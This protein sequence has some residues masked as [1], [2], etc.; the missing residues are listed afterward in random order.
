MSQD[1]AWSAAAF[2]GASKHRQA[3]L[4]ALASS[5]SKPSAIAADSGLL[6]SDVSRALT[7]LREHDMVQ[8]IVDEDTTKGRYYAITDA[9]ESALER[10]GDA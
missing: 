9:G 10:L 4:A 5:P 8:L 2:V 3:V 7:Q 1:N 6:M